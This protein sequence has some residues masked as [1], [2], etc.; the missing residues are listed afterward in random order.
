MAAH[1]H[2][3]TVLLTISAI[4]SV[5]ASV[6]AQAVFGVIPVQGA[7]YDDTG[8]PLDEEIP[9]TFDLYLDGEDDSPFFTSTRLVDVDRGIFSVYLGENVNLDMGYFR[10]GSAVWLAL[11]V[12]DD[13]AMAPFR[14]ASVP[15][16]GYAYYASTA[17]QLGEFTADELTSWNNVTD[18]P[19]GADVWTE[20]QI[21]DAARGVC[22][23]SMDELT[24]IDGS[25]STLDA[26]LLDGEEGEFY[27]DASNLSTG[28]LGVDRFDAYADLGDS[29]H[30]SG[31]DD[32]DILLRADGDALY[33]TDAYADLE[34]DGRLNADLGS[35]LL[36]RDTG[37]SRYIGD[38]Y[39][40]LEA[41]GHLD[42]NADGDLMTA[43]QASN[44]YAVLDG[45]NELAG[46]LSVEQTSAESFALTV[47]GPDQVWGDEEAT[48]AA[49]RVEESATRVLTLDGNELDTTATL[50]INANSGSN[51][52]IGHADTGGGLDVRGGSAIWQCTD[53]TV[54]V[55]EWCID[56]V[57]RE[58]LN[59]AAAARECH[60]DNMS[61]CS[62]DALTQ[63]MLIEED[64]STCASDTRTGTRTT[65]TSSMAAHFGTVGDAISTTRPG[66]DTENSN[67][68]D[69]MLTMEG[70][71][72][73][74]WL[75]SEDTA[76][77]YCCAPINRLR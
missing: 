60:F 32:T 38:A 16:A 53:D 43:E 3:V 71:Q 31:G 1:K 62:F 23:D 72:R 69:H 74:G 25:D 77:F 20:A 50:S 7:L 18:L 61:L 47:A 51:V 73:F 37:D 75:P 8:E 56:R 4:V 67:V 28:E 70:S 21:Q 9:L 2:I 19:A 49:F 17:D 29:G 5:G 48:Q 13:E 66:G 36:T 24:G 58:P 76:N 57:R 14:L 41:G 40:D 52:I 27:T 34:N 54:R 59:L 42:A 10:D 55:A 63:C 6:S 68:R 64:G 45:D 26:D 35:D 46:T 44:L 22:I 15:S 65:L 39:A 33:L 12:G 30:L 11:S